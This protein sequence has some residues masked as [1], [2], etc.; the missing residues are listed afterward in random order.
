MPDVS[1]E[2]IWESR[3]TYFRLKGVGREL[4]SG[5]IRI[6]RLDTNEMLG[7]GGWKKQ[8]S[9]NIVSQTLDGDDLL[10]EISADLINYID[11][12]RAIELQV[13]ELQLTAEILPGELHPY[14]KSKAVQA[15]EPRWTFKPPRRM[16]KPPL[17]PLPKSASSGRSSTSHD[18]LE[19]DADPEKTQDISNGGSTDR[20]RDT[21]HARDED[22]ETREIDEIDE[23]TVPPEREGGDRGDEGTREVDPP[24]SESPRLPPKVVKPPPPPPP[25][26]PETKGSKDKPSETEATSGGARRLVP[27]V[28]AL[29]VGCFVGFFAK[30]FYDEYR[31]LEVIDP[32]RVALL[33]A[34]AFGPLNR[35]LRQVAD[36]SPAGVQ[37]ERIAKRID[38]DRAR[39]FYAEGAAKSRENNKTEAVYWYKQ[40]LLTC[41]PEALAYLGDAVV[42]GQG[43][44]SADPRT[45]FQLLR[46]AA[47]LGNEQAKDQV[48]RLLE[49]EHV[50]ATRRPM[51]QNYR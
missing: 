51:A 35:T 20:A 12:G 48:I 40:S 41:E 47:A 46:L 19:E 44:L 16:G 23:I 33:E 32:Q 42:F 21:G 26:E 1:I 13:D 3:Q 28:A 10:L 2:Q 27:V 18:E 49:S 37:P 43:G 9:S 24:D 50:P 45:G 5:L 4:D 25:E 14:P 38:A 34:A 22:G 31:P 6:R 11:T 7:P 39:K 17:P 8:V 36:K 15:E 30:Y 29:L